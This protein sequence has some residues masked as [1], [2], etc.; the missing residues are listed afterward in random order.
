MPLKQ[1][2]PMTAGQRGTLLSDFSEITRRKPHKP[3]TRGQK[4]PRRE[5]LPWHRDCPAPG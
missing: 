1:L 3:L 2:R 5:E 4:S